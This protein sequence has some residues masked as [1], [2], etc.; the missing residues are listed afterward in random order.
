MLLAMGTDDE[1]MPT[2]SEFM[3]DGECSYRVEEEWLR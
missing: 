1:S 3:S 2:A